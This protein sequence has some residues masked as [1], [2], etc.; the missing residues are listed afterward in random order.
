MTK[1]S[2]CFRVTEK[3]GRLINM[4][5]DIDGLQRGTAELLHLLDMT[6]CLTFEQY[7]HKNLQ[8]LVWGHIKSLC[9]IVGE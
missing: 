9:A 2:L 5:Q 6:A 8:M 3:S 1:Q 7:R 4:Q